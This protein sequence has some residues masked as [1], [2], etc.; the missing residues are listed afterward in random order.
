MPPA[1]DKEIYLAAIVLIAVFASVIIMMINQML[2]RTKEG[3][4]NANLQNRKLTHHIEELERVN[5]N[6]IHIMRVMA[7]DLRNPLSGM[8]GLA[9]MLIEDDGFSEDSRQMLKLIETT[10]IHSMEMLNELLKSGL[11]DESEE[12]ITQKI[13]LKALLYDSVELL[14]FKAREKNQQLIFESNNKPL[15]ADVSYEKIWRVVNNLIIN[16]IKFSHKNDVI[17]VAMW[18]EENE[19]T[20][21][22]ADN[23]IGISDNQKDA[24]FEMF[25]P[26]K[27]VGTG[28]EQPFGLGLSISKKIIDIHKGR[29]WFEKNTEKGTIFYISLPYSGKIN[30]APKKQVKLLVE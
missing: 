24:I 23:G 21:S 14:Q 8:A 26:A 10:G 22:V 12:L 7:H 20:I 17:K 27:Q 11:E 29:I 16:A 13:D 2:K 30:V 3:L 28:G 6:Y 5:K 1:D 15:M 9:A 4:E 19:I 18:I 25:T